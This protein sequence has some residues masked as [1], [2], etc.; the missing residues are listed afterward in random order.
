MAQPLVSII[1]P[2]YNHARYLRECIDGLRAQTYASWEHVIVDD[3]STDDTA[4]VVKSYDDPRITYVRQQNRGVKELAATINS[5]LRRSRGELVTMLASDDRWPADRLAL[6]VPTFEDPR[7]VLCFGRGV[8]MDVEGRPVTEA[9]VPPGV[10]HVV[11][12]PVGSV[13]GSLLVGN[14]IPQYTVLLRRSALDAVGGYLQPPGMLAEDYPTHMALAL[15]GEFRFVDAPLGHYRMHP[16]QMT[17]QHYLPMV[18]TDVEYVRR[19][20]AELPPGTRALTGWTPERLDRALADRVTHAHFEEGRRRLAAGQRKE[21]RARF[22]HAL[23]HGNAATRA[24]A[25][26]GLACAATGLDLERVARATGR[27]PLR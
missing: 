5:G 11:N 18:E 19:F 1:T 26:L 13:L 16:A 8:I 25:A 6:Q 2:T 12:R 21:A 22:A 15:Q 27:T 3:G 7:V 10:G 4:D 20:F 23:R 24:K 9:R 14:W 17:R